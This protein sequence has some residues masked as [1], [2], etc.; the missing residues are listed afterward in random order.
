MCSLSTIQIKEAHTTTT[1]ANHLEKIMTTITIRAQILDG[2]LGDGW[3]DNYRAA[4]VL[5]D[6]TRETWKGDVSELKESGHDV[7]IEI[8]VERNTSGSSRAVEVWC[9]DP[10]IQ[11][12]A[13]SALTDEGRIWDLFCRSEE[14]KSL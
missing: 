14:A 12:K 11:Q 6:F 3:R 13:E 1:T 9:D 7:E 8:D 10:E 4:Q 2:N 5:S